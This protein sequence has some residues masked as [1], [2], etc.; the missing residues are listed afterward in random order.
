MA[1]DKN[2]KKRGGGQEAQRRKQ[3]RLEARR[4]AKAEAEAQRRR[5]EARARVV[6]M[7]MIVGLVIAAFWFLFLRGGTPDEIGG[8]E[9]TKFSGEGTGQHEDGPLT[10]PMTPPVQGAHAPQWAQCGVYAEQVPNENFVHSL[11]HGAV[12]LLYDPARADIEDIRQLEDLA[13]NSDGEVLSAPY[14]GMEPVYSIVSWGERMDLD[15]FDLPAIREYI[16]AFRGKGPEAGATCDNTEDTP[17]E[18]GEVETDPT[19]EPTAS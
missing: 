9:L 13:R 14:A 5:A 19:P 10:Y 11:E 18:P 15:A 17:F 8:H 16:D 4:R 7:V 6:R 1:R 3:E 2:K 12:G